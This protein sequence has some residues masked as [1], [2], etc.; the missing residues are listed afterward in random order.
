VPLK[1][2]EAANSRLPNLDEPGFSD[3]V[4]VRSERQI[5]NTRRSNDHAVSRITVEGRRE[6]IDGNNGIGIQREDVEHI[7]RGSAPEPG[8]KRNR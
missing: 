5:V 6:I 2:I 8:W 1:L 3:G 7:G 4:I